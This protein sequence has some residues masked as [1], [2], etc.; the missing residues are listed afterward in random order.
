MSEILFEHPG[1]GSFP[2]DTIVKEKDPT[3]YVEYYV[4]DGRT[5]V[6]VERVHSNTK[7]AIYDTINRLK[8]EYGDFPVKKHWNPINYRTDGG[9]TYTSVETPSKLIE[10]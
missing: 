5:L 7:T 6:H 4:Y 8:N 1:F 3:G 9:N 2:E 10:E